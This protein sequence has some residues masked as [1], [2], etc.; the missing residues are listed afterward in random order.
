LDIDF[1]ICQEPAA[2]GWIF[3]PK[4][5]GIKKDAAGLK[6]TAQVFDGVIECCKGTRRAN[7][8][9]PKSVR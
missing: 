4:R 9:I 6:P 1:F 7:T 5:A 8:P 3:S 2:Q